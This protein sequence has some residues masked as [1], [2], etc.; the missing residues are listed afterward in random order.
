MLSTLHGFDFFVCFQSLKHISKVLKIW[1]HEP[2]HFLYDAFSV[3][4]I[5]ERGEINKKE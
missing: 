4:L 3:A 1:N 5:D 2:V